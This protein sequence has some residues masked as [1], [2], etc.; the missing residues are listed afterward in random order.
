MPVHKTMA[1]LMVRRAM[2]YGGS[3]SLVTRGLRRCM[4][5]GVF[6]DDGVDDFETERLFSKWAAARRTAVEVGEGD[7]GA[8]ADGA[9]LWV[10]VLLGPG[11]CSQRQR[12]EFRR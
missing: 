2:R 10:Q 5:L 4:T 8:L 3:W 9:R 12:R 1:E 11:H 7:G 6:G